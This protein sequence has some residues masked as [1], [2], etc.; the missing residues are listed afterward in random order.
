MTHKLWL[1]FLIQL[2][3]NLK[4]SKMDR[5]QKELAEIKSTVNTIMNI[6]KSNKWKNKPAF[7]SL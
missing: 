6:V 7:D 4:K 2:K 1:I 3:E 5:T